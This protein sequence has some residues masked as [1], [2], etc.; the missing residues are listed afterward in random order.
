MKNDYILR[1]FGYGSGNM[2]DKKIIE[3]KKQEQ[4]K[5]LTIVINTIFNNI[6]KGAKL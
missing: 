3:D 6:I 1:F 4:E 2:S 5:F